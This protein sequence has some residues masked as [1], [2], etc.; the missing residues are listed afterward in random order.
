MIAPDRKRAALHGYSACIEMLFVPE[1]GNVVE[2]IGLAA[3]AGFDTVEFWG[4]DTKDIAAV[5]EAAA[6]VGVA[7]AAFSVEPSLMLADPANHGR[8]IELL[9]AARDVALRLGARRLIVVVGN[10]REGVPRSEQK[11]HI[12]EALRQ[13]ADVLK[14]SGILLL[15]EPINTGE[16]KDTFI[17]AT[18]DGLDIVDEVGRPE[19]RLLYDMYHSACMGERY[20]EVL[21][22]RVDR[23]AHVHLADNPGRH[24]PGTGSLDWRAGLAWLRANGYAGKV[25]LEYRPA[26][27]TVAGL[28]FIDGRLAL[29]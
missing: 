23:I 13:G 3:E 6:R 29:K 14:G 2:R 26:A 20:A 5:G 11:A 9:T 17:S 25:G 4:S 18:V 1:T 28:R 16:R 19:V 15:V 8:F 7:I 21:A 24:E 22:G 27:G 12:V 10:K